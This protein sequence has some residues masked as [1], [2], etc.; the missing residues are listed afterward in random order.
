MLFSSIVSL[1]KQEEKRCINKVA[2][3]KV[4]KSDLWKRRSIWSGQCLLRN[5]T[6]QGYWPASFYNYSTESYLEL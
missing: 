1:G 3:K 2:M 5:E 4:K 6:S